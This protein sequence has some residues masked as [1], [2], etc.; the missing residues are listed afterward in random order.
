MN[1]TSKKTTVKIALMVLFVFLTQLYANDGVETQKTRQ[2]DAPSENTYYKNTVIIGLNHS[3]FFSNNE[4][5]KTSF[6]LGYYRRKNVCNNLYIKY[7]LKYAD[8]KMDILDIDIYNLFEDDMIDRDTDIHVN[9]DIFELNLFAEYLIYTNKSFS[10]APLVGLGYAQ[11]TYFL[12]NTG[13]D[14]G[15][16]D[17]YDE[18]LD[19]IEG[20]ASYTD[21]NSDIINSG[22]IIHAGIGLIFDQYHC[23]ITY[24]HH[25][26]HIQSIGIVDMVDR[27]I[28]LYTLNLDFGYYF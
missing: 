8:I 2:D 17:Y 24:S 28:N 10:L 7:G 16:H 9:Y 18:S 4:I 27:W 3:Q 15:E 12:N 19:N 21:S 13:Y 22:F 11:F 5:G 26:K 23:D 1:K 20:V 6:N 25:L 14:W